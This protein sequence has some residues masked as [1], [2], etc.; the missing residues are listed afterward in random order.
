MHGLRIHTAHFVII[1]IP[2]ATVFMIAN[3]TYEKHH[4]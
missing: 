1:I 4:F 3:L 2:I